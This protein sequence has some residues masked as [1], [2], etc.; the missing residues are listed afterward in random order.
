MACQPTPSRRVHIPTNE[1]TEVVVRNGLRPLLDGAHHPDREH[2]AKGLCQERAYVSGFEA[3]NAL[4]RDTNNNIDPS[5]NHKF[6]PHEVLSVRE[7]ELLF[8]IGVEANRKV[9]SFLPRFWTR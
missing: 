3:A 6:R 4:M 8:K 9:M 5:H 2:G 7:D 1:Q